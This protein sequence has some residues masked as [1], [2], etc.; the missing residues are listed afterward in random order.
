MTRNSSRDS[1][2][3]ALRAGGSGIVQVVDLEAAEHSWE[4]WRGAVVHGYAF[5]SQVPGPTIEAS[6]GDTLI[7]RLSNQTA[8]PIAIDWD[9]LPQPVGGGNEQVAN[10]VPRGGVI[11]YRFELPSSGTFWYHPQLPPT[12]QLEPHGLYGV[13]LV[14]GLDE[15]GLDGDRVLLIGEMPSSCF[16]QPPSQVPIAHSRSGYVLLVNGVSQPQ[17]E[18]AAGDRERWRLINATEGQH[19]RLSLGGRPFAVITNQSRPLACSGE[20]HEVLM[21]PAER[22]EL[23]VGPFAAE[24]TVLLD[25]VSSGGREDPASGY[26]LATFQIGQ[27]VGQGVPPLPTPHSFP[28]TPFRL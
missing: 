15:P 10:P 16:G 27:P 12:D 24:E 1:A 9:G 14:K 21:R 18:I 26:R 23:V 13:L 22:L 28:S 17:M 8:Q 20:V 3:D 25:A 5:N 19:L 7:V 2:A 4:V 6:V 11:E